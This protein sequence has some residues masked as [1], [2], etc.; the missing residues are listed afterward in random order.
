MVCDG[1]TA[2]EYAA[3]KIRCPD[4]PEQDQ[5]HG[6]YD[7]QGQIIQHDVLQTAEEQEFLQL[8]QTVDAAEFQHSPAAQQDQ[9]RG[10][11]HEMLS[12]KLKNAGK[13]RG[14]ILHKRAPVFVG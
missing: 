13:E 12:E 5:K 6:P 7:P 14:Q 10:K 11:H 2:A 4:T 3:Q 1:K 9:G 8:V